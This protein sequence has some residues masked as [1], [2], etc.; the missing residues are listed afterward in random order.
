M[1]EFFLALC[2][3]GKLLYFNLYPTLLCRAFITLQIMLYSTHFVSAGQCLPLRFSLH[4]LRVSLTRCRIHLA[5]LISVAE[6]LILWLVL[7]MIW[8][9][10]QLYTLNWIFHFVLHFSYYPFQTVLLFMLS[11]SGANYLFFPNKSNGSD[12]LSR[13]NH[14]VCYLKHFEKFNQSKILCFSSYA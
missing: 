11:L 13:F 3:R 4:D 14:M 8:L 1:L 6:A 9:L 7:C 10:Y 2:K 5:Y 12:V